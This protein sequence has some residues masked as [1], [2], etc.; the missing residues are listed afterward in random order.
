MKKNYLLPIVLVCLFSLTSL[1]QTIWNGS[2]SEDWHNVANWSTNRI[3]RSADNVII[4]NAGF[5]PKISSSTLAETSNLT[6]NT[7]AT[8][9]INSANSLTVSGNLTITDNASF[10]LNSGSSL[11]VNGTSTGNIT[12]NRTLATNNWYLVASPVVGET[13]A[14]LFTNAGDIICQW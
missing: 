9:T 3:P 7:G 10:I 14:D 8:L 2:V 12:Y 13:G 1:A 4:A 11:I 5:K 6:I